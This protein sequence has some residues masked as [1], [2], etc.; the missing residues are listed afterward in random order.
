[1]QIAWAALAGAALV[2]FLWAATNMS[3][4]HHTSPSG[5]AERIFGEDAARIPHEPWLSLHVLLRKAYSIVAFAIVGFVVDR[6]LP[7][8]RR[9][10]LR[11]ALIVAAFSTVIEIGQKLH[12]AQE[13]IPSN[14]FDIGCGAFGGWIA[15]ALQ[16]TR[17]VRR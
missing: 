3:V 2:G 9:R 17:T 11:A 5:I 14:L 7:P 6:A 12:H 16:R 8:I 15:I 10:A 13:G 4:Y 1:V